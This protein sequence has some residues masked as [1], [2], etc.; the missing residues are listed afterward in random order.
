MSRF[1]IQLG[2]ECVSEV[3]KIFL[4]ILL[5]TLLSNIVEISVTLKDTNLPLCVLKRTVFR[6]CLKCYL[7]KQHMV[8]CKWDKG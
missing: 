4:G 3:A 6:C 5:I 7:T 2:I 1:I 8:L